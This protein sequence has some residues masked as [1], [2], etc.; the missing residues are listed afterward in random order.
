MT[1]VGRGSDQTDPADFAAV[2]LR[3]APN[4]GLLDEVTT[5]A[6]QTGTTGAAN[7]LLADFAAYQAD[8]AKIGALGQGGRIGDA[9]AHASSAR[10]SALEDRVDSDLSGQ[11]AA[12]QTRFE[13]A[14]AD[15]TSSLSGLSIAIPVLTVLIAALAL[16]GLGQRLREYR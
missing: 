13:R 11:I 5:L 6:R 8:A 9:I 2:M 3:L 4:R 7:Q 14:A 12:S 15:A 16:A 10:S 1:L